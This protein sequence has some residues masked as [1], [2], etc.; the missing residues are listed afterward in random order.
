[1]S[2][3]EGWKELPEWAAWFAE[4]GSWAAEL[5]E[6][7]VNAVVALSVPAREYAAV[8]LAFGSVDRASRTASECVEP[9]LGFEQAWTLQA[10]ACVRVLPVSGPEEGKRAYTGLFRGAVENQYGK[11]YE[12][13]GRPG[14]GGRPG[15]VSW[16][17]ADQ[18]RLQV[19]SW[20]DMPEDY[21][22]RN[23]FSEVFEDQGG[24]GGMLAGRLDDFYRRCS[25]DCVLVGVASTVLA[26]A[27][28]VVAASEYAGLSLQE[29]MHLRGVHTPGTHYRSAVLSSRSDPQ[30]YRDIVRAGKP[31]VAVLDGAAAVRRWMA[32]G[33]AG[34]TVAVIERT[35]PS[36]V[37]AAEV[38]YANRRRSPEDLNLPAGLARALPAGVEALAWRNRGRT[39]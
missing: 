4:A 25:L 5:S 31:A 24:T 6:H 34:V 27:Q 20:P 26:E 32:A 7:G 11:V 3:G 39:R 28:E 13:A 29:L 15:M 1:M 17:P 12:L 8:L 10:G 35:S 16:F 33:L 14:P 9:E 22:D 37:A 2:V 18:Y 38:L 21:A 23:R 19:L 30:E 36:A